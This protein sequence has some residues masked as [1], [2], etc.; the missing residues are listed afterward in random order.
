[1]KYED[2]REGIDDILEEDEELKEILDDDFIKSFWI[3]YA[4]CKELENEEYKRVEKRKY[5]MRRDRE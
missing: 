4:V 3:C 5:R 1:M 2:F